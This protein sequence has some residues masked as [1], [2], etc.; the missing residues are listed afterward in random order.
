MTASILRNVQALTVCTICVQV[1]YNN[2][3]PIVD[4]SQ[5]DISMVAGDPCPCHLD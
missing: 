5:D 2:G 3:G 4:I 1:V